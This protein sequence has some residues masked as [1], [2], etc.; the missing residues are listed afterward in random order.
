MTKPM[1]A[2]A[3]TAPSRAASFVA[4]VAVVLTIARVL[5]PP[6]TSLNG[7][8]YAFVMTGPEWSRALALTAAELGLRAQIHWAALLVQ[9]AVVWAIAVGALWCLRGPKS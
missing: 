9:I 4:Y 7:T 5:F 2:A 8:E 6:F 1:I 3:R